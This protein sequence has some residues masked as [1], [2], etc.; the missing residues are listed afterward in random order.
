MIKRSSGKW[1]F[2]FF[3]TS[4]FASGKVAKIPIVKKLKQPREI[5]HQQLT[6]SVTGNRVEVSN[7]GINE[8]LI[9]FI[10]ERLPEMY[11]GNYILEH[12]SIEKRLIKMMYSL[13]QT[14][15]E[16][17]Y[18][19]AILL[20]TVVEFEQAGHSGIIKYTRDSKQS[21]T[22]ICNCIV[23]TPKGMIK[24]D[25]ILAGSAMSNFRDV[26][27]DMIA[28]VITLANEQIKLGKVWEEIRLDKSVS[29]SLTEYKPVVP[30]KNVP[31]AKKRVEAKSSTK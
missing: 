6:L 11:T 17:R 18:K 24:L 20:E 13:G 4:K 30:P 23:F 10:E 29:I 16:K 2:T 3:Q 14:F 7:G 27:C 19:P 25:V 9:Y 26:D 1:N 5:R 22:S 21:K 12:K 8:N 31:T 28:L 15:K